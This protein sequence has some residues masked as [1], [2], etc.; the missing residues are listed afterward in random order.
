MPS[1]TDRS[2]RAHAPLGPT[3]AC[4]PLRPTEPG[5]ATTTASSTSF[6]PS[7]A[8]LAGLAIASLALLGCD[9]PDDGEPATASPTFDADPDCF[10]VDVA[11]TDPD[12]VT[13]GTVTVPLDHDTP[14][15]E[16]ID[17]AV[18]TVAGG[19]DAAPIVVLGGG[20]GETVV[21]SALAD[22][23]HLGLYTA[24]D[25]DVVLLDQRGVGLSSPELS[26]T[27]LGDIE[28]GTVLDHDEYLE[29]LTACR[30]ELTDAGVDLDAFDHSGNARDV[31]AVREALGHEVVLRGSSYGTHLALHA[32]SLDPEGIEALVL[33][34]PADP[35][36]N[37]VQHMAGGFQDALNRIA[38]ACAA[39]ERCSEPFGDLQE[40][41]DDVVDRLADAPEEVTAASPLGGDE[42]TRTYTPRSFLDAVFMVPYAPDGAAF[43]PALVHQAREGDLEP[44]AGL[45][46]LLEEGMADL[47]RGMYHS[48]VCT[49]EAAAF[50]REAARE[51]VHWTAVEDHWF[52]HATI[53]GARNDA[54]CELWD[55]ATSFDPAELTLADDV[56]AL[57]VTGGFDHVTPPE[58]GERLH[59]ELATSYLVEVP[60]LAH[61]PLEG[62]DLFGGCGTSIVEDFLDDPAAEPDTGCVEQVPDRDELGSWYG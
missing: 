7:T 58:T 39:D 34:S 50:D 25:R 61:A 28:L 11:A 8:V 51:S 41:I 62:L 32:A 55:V 17:L 57:I 1:R 53:G 6:R 42:V 27:A 2:A 56:P 54:A 12:E 26:C 19:S 22:P 23:D 15:A 20:P 49:G 37:Y 47:P 36:D 3:N 59:A 46:A 31:H 16:T 40:A 5:A 4:R 14:E 52:E 35:S 29:A 43:L 45:H 21:E 10:G 60:T 13:C 24:A 38:D 48:M 18:A 44:I 9:D 30:E 33:S